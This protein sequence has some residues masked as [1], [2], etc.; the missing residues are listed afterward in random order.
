MV[1]GVTLV[2]GRP[3]APEVGGTER[4]CSQPH[5]LP[6]CPPPSPRCSYFDLLD[7]MHV[8]LQAS[9]FKGQEPTLSSSI[10]F[11][12]TSPHSKLKL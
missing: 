3:R 11:D 2:P 5:D 9:K 4:G 8:A 10:P 1:E 12:F 6:L 7:A